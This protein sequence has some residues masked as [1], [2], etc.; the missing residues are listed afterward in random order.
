MSF[1]I[2]HY[3]ERAY[4]GEL[5]EELPIK[6][7]CLKLKEI[8]IKEPNLI[9]LSSPITLVGDIHGQFYDL[10]EIFRIGGSVPN[11]N[12][13]FLGD[14]VDRGAHSVETIILLGLLKL[15][16]PNRITLIRGNHENK[17]TT[18][19]YGFYTEC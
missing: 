15:K 11:I 1:D 16:H 17:V 18:Q 8:L 7:I 12:Y 9:H 13:L 5:L 2:D 19:T 4:K 6:I 14:Y 3:L 10:L